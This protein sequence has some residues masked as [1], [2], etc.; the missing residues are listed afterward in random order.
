MN[1]NSLESLTI[2][3]SGCDSVFRP[4]CQKTD[5]ASKLDLNLARPSYRLTSYKSVIG[6]AEPT[7]NFFTTRQLI[8]SLIPILTRVP[9]IYT[10]TRQKWPFNSLSDR[11]QFQQDRNF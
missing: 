2:A 4:I 1:S 3:E 5:F 6:Y 10:H 8:A 9:F 7:E 11:S